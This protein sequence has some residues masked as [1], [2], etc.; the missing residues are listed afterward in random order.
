MNLKPNILIVEDNPA[1][2]RLIKEILK[3]SNVSHE[4]Y[5]A[6]DGAIA[7]EMLHL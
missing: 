3:E 2:V 4:L 7:L 5:H 1:D 6:Q